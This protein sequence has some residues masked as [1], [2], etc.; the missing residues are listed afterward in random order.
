M[1]YFERLAVIKFPAYLLPQPLSFWKQSSSL[2]KSHLPGI[3]NSP[4]TY[5]S[6]VLVGLG[7]SQFSSP[8][9]RPSDWLR[10]RHEG[11]SQ[12]NQRK[13]FAKVPEKDQTSS[14]L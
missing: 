8:F 10:N 14:F 4:N 9:P 5:F 3:S 11:E 12:A 1:G 13:A 6:S 2:G 7:L